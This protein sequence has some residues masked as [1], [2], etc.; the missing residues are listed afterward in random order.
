MLIPL[1]CAFVFTEQLKQKPGFSVGTG[2]L[3]RQQMIVWGINID[4]ALHKRIPVG[5]VKKCLL[6]MGAEHG[7]SLFSPNSHTNPDGIE[8]NQ[9]KIDRCTSHNHAIDLTNLYVSF[10]K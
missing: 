7:F 2:K 1:L 10:N 9:L 3:H 4:P 8:G 5:W 6:T